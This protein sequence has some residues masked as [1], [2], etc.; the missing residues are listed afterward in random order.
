MSVIMK[1]KDFWPFF[2]C[3][4][5]QS[6]PWPWE[7]II[8]FWVC[9]FS[10]VLDE[11]KRLL[12]EHKEE[13]VSITITGHSLGAAVG[14]LNAVDIVKNG[15]NRHEARLDSKPCPVTA[16]FFGSPRV[17]DANFRSTFQSEEDLPPS[18]GQEHPRRHSHVPVG[19]VQGCRWGAP[20]RQ[21]PVALPEAPGGC[22]QLPQ[23]RRVPAQNRGDPRGIRSSRISRSWARDRAW[24]RQQE[25]RHGPD[26]R[27]VVE[28]RGP[29]SMTIWCTK[30][31]RFLQA[32]DFFPL[33]SREL[34]NY[35]EFWITNLSVYSKRILD[36]TVAADAFSD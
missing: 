20:Y 34:A 7:M 31:D 26:E 33:S 32:L 35:M 27:W 24:S 15:F 18:T 23:P 12:E 9:S 29:W 30:W 8:S 25:I 6:I 28:A 36:L 14:T 21:P 1:V 19:R 22:K 11:G 16:F 10:K 2:R 17:G 13:E 4:A 3:D 5:L